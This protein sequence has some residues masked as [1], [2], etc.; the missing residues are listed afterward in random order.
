[1]ASAAIQH[2]HI[3]EQ[4]SAQDDHYNQFSTSTALSSNYQA[5]KVEPRNVTTT[6]HYF[7]DNEDGSPPAPSYAGKPET[8]S[9]PTLPQ[10]VTVYDIRGSEDQH[11]LDTK[12][13]Q[14]VKHDSKEKDFLS[15]EQ[16]KSIYYP[17]TEELLRKVSV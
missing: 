13:F 14:V 12:G 5:P 11:T 4:F 8:F 9:R 7:K 10:Q 16:I 17:E 1:M 2:S 3:P 15:D 6:L